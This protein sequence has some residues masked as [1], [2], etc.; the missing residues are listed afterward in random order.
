MSKISLSV[1]LSTGKHSLRYYFTGV[2]GDVDLPELTVV[3]LVDGVQFMYFDSKT[4]KAVPK[5]DWIRENL[6]ADY[7][8]IET[9]T[10]IGQ[11][12]TFKNN[13][14]VAKNRFNHS[15]GKFINYQFSCLEYSLISFILLIVCVLS[16]IPYNWI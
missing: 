12:E 6:K 7:W 8:E 1:S 14:H 11:H 10:N 16:K 13:M 3:G 5:T 15:D 2:A 4:M 9:Q